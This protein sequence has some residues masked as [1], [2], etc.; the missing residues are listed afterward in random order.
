M[1]QKVPILVFSRQNKRIFLRDRLT[2]KIY[3]SYRAHNYT[4]NNDAEPLIQG[5]WAPAPLGFLTLSSPDFISE[6][7]RKEFYL[8]HFGWY[9]VEPGESFVQKWGEFEEHEMGRVRFAL[10]D[11]LS[12]PAFA[13]RAA[14]ER[15]LLIH[16][17]KTFETPTK[18]CIRMTG[19]DIELFAADWIRCSR[20]FTRLKL[21]R[22]IQ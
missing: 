2:E 18:G 22:I 11:P 9:R 3:F 20:N 14:W 4:E 8:S 7:F 5:S 17:G 6:E 16:A 13:D 15:E 19:Y 10:G 21:I 1:I 12:P